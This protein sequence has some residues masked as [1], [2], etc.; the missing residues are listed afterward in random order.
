MTLKEKTNLFLQS[1]D[2]G[3]TRACMAGTLRPIRV[4]WHAHVAPEN[5]FNLISPLQR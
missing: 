4:F 2:H 3:L 1:E 5:E